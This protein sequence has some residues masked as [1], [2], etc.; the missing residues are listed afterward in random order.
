[1]RADRLK[2][3]L[4]ENETKQ[5][6]LRGQQQLSIGMS[7]LPPEGGNAYV[8]VDTTL[9]WENRSAYIP[10]T[11]EFIVYSDRETIDG[12]VYP[13]VK[14]GDGSA[15]V[16]ALPFLDDNIML[17]V[18]N[19]IDDT[20]VHITQNE[21]TNWNNKI[22]EPLSDG[23]NGQVLTTDGHG[24]RSWTNASGGAV[25]DDTAGSG[26]TDKTWSA[27]KITSELDNKA[28]ISDV[29]TLTDLIDDD[30]GSGDT[31]VTW[32]ANKITGEFD[33]QIGNINVLLATI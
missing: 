5:I 12:V 10:R 21:R 24:G 22:D 26:V 4:S 2:I 16:A 28:D 29:P 25:I 33:V 8:S 3:V 23:T 11:G 7:S 19:H 30:A 32:S 18:L 14:I 13:G 6:R 15:S 1:M 31:D 17:I 9:G 27:N 20:V